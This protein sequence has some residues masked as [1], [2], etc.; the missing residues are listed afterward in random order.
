MEALCRCNG[1]D[2]SG[3]ACACEQGAHVWR[4]RSQLHV[5]ASSCRRWDAKAE[6]GCRAPHIT[7]SRGG[8]PI[9]DMWRSRYVL[10]NPRSAAAQ[11]WPAT[12]RCAR[13][14]ALIASAALRC[15]ATARS[16][17]AVDKRRMSGGGHGA[18]WQ[19]GPCCRPCRTFQHAAAEGG[20]A[21]AAPASCAAGGGRW[22][23]LAPRA[24]VAARACRGGGRACA[25]RGA[26]VGATSG[27]RAG[28]VRGCLAPPPS[29][30]ARGGAHCAAPGA[31]R[32]PP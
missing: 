15:C 14:L 8:V 22:R 19:R 20:G 32:T 16:G 12:N 17:P 3:R 5:Q 4:E 26:A 6:H 29:R 30:R 21:K 10:R 25:L 2:A 13:A 27:G 11:L 23:L 31:T 7:H 1:A 24:Q 28:A 9:N 18:E